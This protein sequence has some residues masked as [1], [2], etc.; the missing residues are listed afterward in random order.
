MSDAHL[1]NVCMT[2]TYVV[3]AF[4]LG[5]TITAVIFT[6]AFVFH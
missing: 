3:G 2:G 6:H 4:F 5:L 1:D